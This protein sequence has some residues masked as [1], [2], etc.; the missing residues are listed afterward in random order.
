MGYKRKYSTFKIRWITFGFICCV[1]ITIFFFLY[2]RNFFFIYF[3]VI[4]FKWMFFIFIIIF[5]CM[6]LL[7]F[8]RIHTTYICVYDIYFK[9]YQDAPDSKV[10]N[11]CNRMMVSFVSFIL[12]YLVSVL[13]LSLVS[14][15]ALNIV[16]L[17]IS[18]SFFIIFIKQY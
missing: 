15:F 13:S 12:F 8:I 7:Q 16:L 14:L 9:N 17:Q 10:Y 1:I 5:F 2:K 18:F 4:L 6:L 3:I 11:I